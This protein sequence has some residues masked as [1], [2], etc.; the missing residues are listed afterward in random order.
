MYYQ[1]YL[2]TSIEC[3]CACCR[4]KYVINSYG[5]VIEKEREQ[6]IGREMKKELRADC[7]I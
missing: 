6:E 5:S 3:C 4:Y 2:Q 1:M 7:M